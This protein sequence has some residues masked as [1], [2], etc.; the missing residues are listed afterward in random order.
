MYFNFSE[1][2]FVV[3]VFE[4]L[5]R[6]KVIVRNNLKNIALFLCKDHTSTF[7][8]ACRFLILIGLEIPI[9]LVGQGIFL[10]FW[11]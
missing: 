6:S 5:L 3:I 11:R 10:F 4:L 1:V 2:C 7:H 9:S 8:Y